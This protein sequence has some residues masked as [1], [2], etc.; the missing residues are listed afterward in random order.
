MKW[1]IPAKTFLL[2]EYIAMQGGPAIILTTTPCFEVE[3]CTSKKE[4]AFHPDSPAGQ[5]L[6]KN[7][8]GESFTWHDPYQGLGGLGASSAQFV[9]SY[10]AASHLQEKLISIAEMMDQYMAVAWSGE[11]KRPSGYDVRAQASEGCV[12]IHQAKNSCV[13]YPWP[14]HDVSFILVH[15]GKKLATHEHLKQVIFEEAG[16][17]PLEEAAL[18]AFDA[19]KIGDGV[20]LTQAVNAY[21]A[22]LLKMNLVAA[23]TLT[24]M[25]HIS[26]LVHPIAMKGCGALGADVILLLIS[27]AKLLETTDV[28]SHAGY[29]IV[30][31]SN[32]LYDSKHLLND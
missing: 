24:L 21:H 17:A 1:L 20:E 4:P 19:F 27:S 7:N 13:S 14:F 25:K 15:T 16:S 28:L 18:S 31:T 23:H 12:L 10:W 6:I 9:G 8:P 11:G 3:L 26:S 22:T 29:F 30:A 2:G 5:F 32:Q